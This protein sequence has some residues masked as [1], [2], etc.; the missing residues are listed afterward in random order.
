MHNMSAVA[1]DTRDIP[2]L[3]GFRLSML[4]QIPRA[5]WPGSTRA[6]EGTGSASKGAPGGQ[7][8]RQIEAKVKHTHTHA[9]E[10]VETVEY[11]DWLLAQDNESPAFAKGLEL[12]RLLPRLGPAAEDKG[13]L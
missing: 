8:R 3:T 9:N 2:M 6:P 11:L 7:P 4:L 13:D 5:S 12:R 1:T 10:Y